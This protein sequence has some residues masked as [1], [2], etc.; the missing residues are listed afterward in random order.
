MKTELIGHPQNYVFVLQMGEF[1]DV[2]SLFCLCSYGVCFKHFLSTLLMKEG[3]LPWGNG[4]EKRQ[5]TWHWID[6]IE[7]RLSITQTYSTGEQDSA[8]HTRHMGMD[9]I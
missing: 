4:D 7:G 8:C 9:W 6:K 2:S 3:F 1:I 5:Y